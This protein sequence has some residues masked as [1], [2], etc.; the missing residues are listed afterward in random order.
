MMLRGFAQTVRVPSDGGGC[1]AN[2]SYNFYS[3]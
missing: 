2:W 3:G 1:L